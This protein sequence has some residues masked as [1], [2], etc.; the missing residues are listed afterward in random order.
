M[1]VNST[2]SS[3]LINSKVRICIHVDPNL[4]IEYLD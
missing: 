2:L 3:E 1:I 4:S